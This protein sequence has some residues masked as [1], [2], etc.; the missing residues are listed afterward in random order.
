M[1]H[2]RHFLKLFHAQLGEELKSKRIL[3]GL[4]RESALGSASVFCL[5]VGLAAQE[6]SGHEVDLGCGLAMHIVPRVLAAP[7][8]HEGQRFPAPQGARRGRWTHLGLCTGLAV[9]AGT[10]AGCSLM[11]SC[12][13]TD[14]L[15][16]A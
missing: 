9:L 7:R 11:A 15:V 2:M 14:A 12:P 13:R 5:Q 10:L 1:R 6:R 8:R 3:D 16:H 4:R